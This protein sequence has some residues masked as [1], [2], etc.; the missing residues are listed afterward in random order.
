[1]R[2]VRLRSLTVADGLTRRVST[3]RLTIRHAWLRQEPV[4][5]QAGIRGSSAVTSRRY[6]YAFEIADERPQCSCPC[7]I[8]RHTVCRG[9]IEPGRRAAMMR[10][11]TSGL[12]LASRCLPCAEASHLVSEAPIGCGAVLDGSEG[13]W[14]HGY[15]LDFDSE[16]VGQRIVQDQ[17]SAALDGPAH[18][19]RSERS[20]ARERRPLARIIGIQGLPR[21]MRR[22][23][24]IAPAAPDT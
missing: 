8:Y 1:M 10:D 24:S 20:A 22:L 16:L 17:R 7:S 23:R 21:A 3:M 14:V 18:A 2:P 15:H 4:V 19:A 12:R 5:E 9:S 11:R 6:L 13:H